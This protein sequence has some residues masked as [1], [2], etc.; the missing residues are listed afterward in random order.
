MSFL[1]KLD[2]L[3]SDRNINYEAYQEQLTNL[4]SVKA[5]EVNIER[6]QRLLSED[7]VSAYKTL[8]REH[9]RAFWRSFIKAI[10]VNDQREIVRIVF[11]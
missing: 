10:Y 7:F 6:L 2:K 11:L 8:D 9:K 5:P 4:E 3:M 1:T